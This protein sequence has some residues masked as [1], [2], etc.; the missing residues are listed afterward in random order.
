MLQQNAYSA[1]DLKNL[2]AARQS[3]SQLPSGNMSVFHRITTIAD[4]GGRYKK[5]EVV[6]EF[7]ISPEL[8]FFDC[9]FPG[10]PVMP[11][12]LGLDGLWQLAGFFLS[13][14]GFDGRGRALGCGDVKFF[15]EILPQTKLVTYKVYPRRILERDMT[16]IIADGEV[17]ADGVQIYEARSLRVA[18]I[19]EKLE[20]V[21]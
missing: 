8:W 12:C 9:H 14:K 18:L 19:N 15:G 10:D 7:D 16:L 6:A 3:T 4:T 11:G 2:A 1:A 17:F 21:A 5:G 13:W 20:Y